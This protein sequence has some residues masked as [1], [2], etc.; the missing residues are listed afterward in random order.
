MQFKAL[1]NM[2][3]IKLIV[4]CS[5]MMCFQL[6]FQLIFTRNRIMKMVTKTVLTTSLNL[7]IQTLIFYVPM[8]PHKIVLIILYFFSSGAIHT[9]SQAQDDNIPSTS[10]SSVSPQT[11]IPYPKASRQLRGRKNS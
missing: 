5:L 6:V 1:V 4:L 3:F 9:C 11:I 2:I 8:Q 10:S 7:I